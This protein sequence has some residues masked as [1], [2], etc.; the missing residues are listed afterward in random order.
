MVGVSILGCPGARERDEDNT[1]CLD[2]AQEVLL[3]PHAGLDGRAGLESGRLGRMWSPAGKLIGPALGGG[4][5]GKGGE[6]RALGPAG[7]WA[8]LAVRQTWGEEG[9]APVSGPGSGGW[10]WWAPADSALAV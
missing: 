2:V 1:L 8:V 6:G 10:G 3:R 4:E 9:G 5:W 7:E